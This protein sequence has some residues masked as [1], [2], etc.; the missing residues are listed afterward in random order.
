MWPVAGECDD[1]PHK[2]TQTQATNP[3]PLH[4]KME[5]CICLWPGFGVV[6]IF[7]F[8]STIT[9]TLTTSFSYLISIGKR[10]RVVDE[11]IR[12]RKRQDK[13]QVDQRKEDETNDSQS[14]FLCLLVCGHLLVFYIPLSSLSFSLSLLSSFSFYIFII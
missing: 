11:E 4:I 6:F 12:K 2:P 8:L 10:V 7:L 13:K 3:F 14:W 1:N 9:T 5:K